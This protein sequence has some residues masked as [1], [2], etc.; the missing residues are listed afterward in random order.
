MGIASRFI[1]YG[2]G[3]LGH[4]YPQVEAF[5]DPSKLDYQPPTPFLTPEQR[6]FIVDTAKVTVTDCVSAGLQYAS[7]LR[8][9][10]E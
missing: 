10:P 8:R 7:R 4:P 2:E 6:Q 9:R 3:K 1:A 5:G